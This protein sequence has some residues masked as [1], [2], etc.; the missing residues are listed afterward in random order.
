[1]VTELNF[2]PPVTACPPPIGGYGVRLIRLWIQQAGA[3]EIAPKS[4][5]ACF[6]LRLAIASG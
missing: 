6:Y 5:T 2:G 4:V 1:M 3:P